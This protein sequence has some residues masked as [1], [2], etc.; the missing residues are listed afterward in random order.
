MEINTL[1]KLNGRRDVFEFMRGDFKNEHWHK[2][3]IFLT[4]EAFDVLHLYIE[5]VLPDFNYFGPNKVNRE[6]W[7]QIA[8]NA[9][10]LN[11]S[12][13]IAFLRFFN[14]IDYWVK[15]NFEEHICFSICGP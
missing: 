10:S 7:N 13:D 3:S 6:Q 15:E 12:V 2:S 5:E 11:N 8:F 14:S 1:E 4:T 9:I